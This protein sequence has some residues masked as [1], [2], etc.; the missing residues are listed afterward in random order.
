[1][2]NLPNLVPVLLLLLV[3]ALTVLIGLCDPRPARA[4]SIERVGDH[5]ALSRVCAS[6][7]GLNGTAEECAAILAVL[8]SRTCDGCSIEGIA[9]RYSDRVFDLDR[10][11]PR[12]WVAFLR[13]DGRQPRR[14]PSSV[15]VRGNVVE[16]APWSAFRER[17]LTLHATAGRVLRGEVDHGLPIAPR[18]WG[19]RADRARARRMG[20]IRIE[21]P[22]TWRNDFYD[23]PPAEDEFVD[24]GLDPD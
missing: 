3:F 10:N 15:L 19:G 18:H 16:H 24:T 13:A 9:R 12:A 8:R 11:D 21:A 23:L 20:L 5:L 14:W 7:I 22:E 2:K 6:E 1:M 4:Q 17:W